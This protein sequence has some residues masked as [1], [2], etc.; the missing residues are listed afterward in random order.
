[1]YRTEIRIFN[2]VNAIFYKYIVEFYQYFRN[3]QDEDVISCLQL[4]TF[5]PDETIDEYRLLEGSRINQ[6]KKALAYETTKIVHG[7]AEARKCA[8]LAESLF[9]GG[10][11]AEHLATTS[12]NAEQAD[13]GVG[14]VDLLI[15]CGLSPS[16]SEA[17]RLIAQGGII[18]AGAKVTSA[19]FVVF[20]KDF[21]DD[22][23]L[24]Q[25]GKKTFHRVAI[26]R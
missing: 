22:C 14:I 2:D 15:M 16:R 9:E 11:D 4:L 7:E 1:M 17:R 19:D 10:G 23:L 25:K 12:L 24:L 3:V 26:E 21:S 20:A 5:L 18:A 13:S 8:G 6:A